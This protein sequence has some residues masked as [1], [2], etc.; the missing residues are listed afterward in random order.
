MSSRPVAVLPKTVVGADHVVPLSV[1]VC[2]SWM[3]WSAPEFSAE[4]HTLD[5]RR[6]NGSYTALI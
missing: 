2:K 1:E 5:D 6:K 4:E 3:S